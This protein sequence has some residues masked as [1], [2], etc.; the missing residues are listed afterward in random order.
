MIHVTNDP[1]ISTMFK[2]EELQNF[3]ARLLRELDESPYTLKEFLK[4]GW[5][6]TY[7]EI[8]NEL[9]KS[10][11]PIVLDPEDKLQHTFLE[12]ERCIDGARFKIG[13][14]VIDLIVPEGRALPISKMYEDD[15][16]LHIKLDV[17][18]K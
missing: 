4:N 16:G 3:L 1:E 12:V 6:K 15:R 8:M 9:T 10:F 18:D 14:L 13:D 17:D 2:N 11:V 7:T 5:E